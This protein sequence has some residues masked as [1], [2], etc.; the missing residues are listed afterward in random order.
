MM[1]NWLKI[2][3]GVAIVL[4]IIGVLLFTGY[5]YSLFWIDHFVFDFQAENPNIKTVTGVID[6]DD[7][8]IQELYLIIEGVSGSTRFIDQG[9]SGYDAVQ[10]CD[11][12]CINNNLGRCGASYG[13]SGTS[14]THCFTTETVWPDW[15]ILEVGDANQTITSQEIFRWNQSYQYEFPFEVNAVHG[16]R[17]LC[18]DAFASAEDCRQGGDCDTAARTCTFN[19]AGISSHDYGQITVRTNLRNVDLKIS[20][21]TTNTTTT[22]TMTDQTTTT[23]IE[24]SEPAGS[25]WVDV[26]MDHKI[27]IIIGVVVVALILVMIYAGATGG[28]IKFD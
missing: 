23:T 24:G 1:K 4:S 2:L 18:D 13:F 26:I 25:G 15:M 17:P 8:D 6:P 5:K 3:I 22:T 20:G 11:N 7:S 10:Q 14:S 19:I 16:V 21:N 9:Y 28:E 27:P 12:Y